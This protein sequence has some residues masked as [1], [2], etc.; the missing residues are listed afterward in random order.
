MMKQ[1]ANLYYDDGKDKRGGARLQ[2]AHQRAAAHPE[3]P[4]F[5]AKIVDCVLRAGNKKLTVGR[6]GGW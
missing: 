5:Q 3:A 2:H 6:S 4:G 1:L